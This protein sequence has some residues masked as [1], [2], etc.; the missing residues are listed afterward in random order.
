M[1]LH[2]HNRKRVP[3]AHGL[4]SMEWEDGM[5]QAL[6]DMALVL[7]DMAQDGMTRWCGDNLQ[8]ECHMYSRREEFQNWRNRQLE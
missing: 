5:A 4:G 6:D 3:L 1:P 7:D 2:L 8:D